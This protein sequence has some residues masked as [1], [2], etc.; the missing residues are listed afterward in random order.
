MPKKIKNICFVC[1]AFP[2]KNEGA[3]LRVYYEYI[4]Y[5]LK[6]KYSVTLIYFG[7]KVKV[8]NIF[9]NNKIKIY[10]LPSAEHLV[11]NKFSIIKN[12]DECE[13]IEKIVKKN[14]CELVLGFDIIAIS[15]IIKIQDIKKVGWLGDLRFLT[16][17]YNFYYSI[18][19]NP[20]NLKNIFYNI[21]Q[22][23]LLKNFYKSNLKYLHK[24]IVSSGSSVDK[25]NRIN[26]PSIF[27]PYPWSEKFRFKPKEIKKPT[28]LFF[29]NLSGLGSRSSIQEII[30]NIYPMMIK[31]FGKK[32]F[33]ILI[34]GRN[35]KSSFLSKID[36]EFYPELKYLGFIKDI[37]NYASKCNAFIFP[38]KVPIGNRCRLLSCLSSGI[39]LI[40]SESVTLGNTFLKNN[41][42]CLI[43]KNSKEILKHMSFSYKNDLRINA[44]IHNGKKTYK[45]NYEP[46]KASKKLEQKILNL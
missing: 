44:L 46:Y 38:G 41:F 12:L 40:A 39:L 15:Q 25:L 31:H 26:I 4:N 45:D 35:F 30:G 28:F 2:N 1:E 13:E 32:K 27:L 3:S 7:K 14:K 29:G 42:N 6:K 20:L 36:L 10:S 24:V 37:G 23:Y 11:P 21:Y 19:E 18:L 22:N 5:F 43:G 8:K 33:Q 34:G 17:M 9:K 16:N